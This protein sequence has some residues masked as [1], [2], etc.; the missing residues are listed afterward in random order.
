M[1]RLTSL[2]VL[3]LALLAGKA[4]AARP[5][6]QSYI[7]RAHEKKGI[8]LRPIIG[9]LSQPGDPAPKGH[10]YIA[11]SYVKFLES[12]G[13]RVVPVLPDMPRDEVKRLFESV[14]GFLIPGGAQDLRPGAPFYDTAEHMFNLTIKANDNGD[15]FPLHG[16]C[17]GFE[18]LAII[19]ASN[20]S[21]LEDFDA[22][23]L[24][25]PL[26]YTDEAPSSRFFSS[27]PPQVYDHLRTQ[28]YAM[29]NHAHGLAWTAIADNPKLLDLF[30]VLTLS[31]DRGGRVYVS[32]MEAKKYP[33]TA[34]QWHPE[35][36]AFEWTPD[37]DIPH[38]PDAI[39]VT[40]EVAN[41][42]VGEA[43]K[44][45]HAPNSQQDEEDM[46]I[47][48]WAPSYTGKHKYKGEEVDFDESYFFPEYRKYKER[49]QQLRAERQQ[50]Q[51]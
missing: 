24:P 34:V 48:N 14:N 8:N 15:Y 17:L 40:Q 29:Q 44:N 30:K 1:A 12:A 4:E 10:S 2:V 16:T 13:A 5:I 45:F 38:D 46:L 50:R 26:F 23:N 6:E 3:C 42:I 21:I 41:F 25:S 43:R 28:P 35:K 36:N 11:A 31:V 49:L 27:L 37:K 9:V 22:E 51:E 18:T 7:L 39:E 33:I 47:Y 19:A 20:H 32:S